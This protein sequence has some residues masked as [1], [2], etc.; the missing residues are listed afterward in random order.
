[1]NESAEI[2][3]RARDIA[4]AFPGVQALAGVEL[5]L[6]AGEVHALMGQNGAGKSTLIKVLTG[7]YAPDAGSIELAGKPVVPV[8]PIHA[9][10]LGISAVHQESHLLPNLSVA[11]NICAGRYPRKPWLRGGGIDWRETERRA[12]E[13]LA[14]LGIDIDVTQLAGGL[15]AAL[16][17]LATVARAVA[18]DARVLILDEPTSSLDADEVKALFALIRRLRDKGVAILFVTHFLD[19]VYEICDRMTVLRNGKFVGEYVCSK[20]DA[21]GLVAAMVGREVAAAEKSPGTGQGEASDRKPVL[22]AK[23]LS[24][25]GQLKPVDIDLHHGEVLGLAGLLG[26][27]RT[28]LARLLFALDGRDSG[29]ITI[30]GQAV[31]LDNPADA[32]KAGLG[33]CP[34]DRK[35]SGIV[36]DLSVRENIALALQAR[37]GLRKFLKVSEQREIAEKLVKALGVKTAS[38]ETPIGQLSGGNQQKAI[39]ARWLATHPRVLILDEPTRGIDVAAKQELMSEILELARGGT[40]V[41]FISAEIEEVVRVSDRIMVLRDRAKAGDLPRGADEDAVYSLIAGTP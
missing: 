34:E 36:A 2:V 27:G 8:S 35:H 4:R 5:T 31:K 38:I 15:P 14:N 17:Q 1:M 21:R 19:Q 25:R 24:R 9:Q 6:R 40:A 41:L 32:L 3:L 28:E 22:C 33:F 30:D 7:V 26:S 11:E 10:E 37:M 12:R 20:L 18:T 16:Q 39:I 23:N 29:E 13:L